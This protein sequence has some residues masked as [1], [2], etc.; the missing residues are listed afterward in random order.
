[1]GSYVPSSQAERE[2]MLK[3]IGVKSVEDL[4]AN[5]PADMLLKGELDLPSGLSELEVEQAMSETA[6][7]NKT[8]KT[9]LRGCGAY[10]HHIPS[11]VKSV[12]NKEQFVTAYTPYQ[13]EI[14]Q[15]ILQ[16]IFEY[17]TMICSLTGM[18]V[19]NA[20]VYDGASATAEAAAMCR[21]RKRNTVYISQAVNPEYIKVLKTYAFGSDTTVVTVPCVNGKTDKEALKNLLNEEAACFILQTP[22]YYGLFEDASEIG[23]IV[24]S[25]GAKFVMNCNPIALAIMKTPAEC[26]ADVAIGDGQPLGM[27]VA[28]GGPYLGFMASK[29]AMARKLPGRI[30]GQTV[31][32]E[33]KRGFV[34]TLQAREQHIRREK[35]SSNICSNQA[36][37]ALTAGVYMSAMG[38]Y[39][40]KRAATL[41]M[42]K[43]H[44]L[45]SELTKIEGVSLTFDGEFF[46][47]FTAV[48]PKAD[49]I[50]AKLDENGILGGYP[51]D[52]GI[53]WCAT[54][55]ATKAEL[56]RT[57]EIVKEVL[58]K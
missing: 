41:S 48:M 15:G 57:V 49:E 33:G 16:S 56:D 42:S 50:L 3:V 36:L 45:A 25:F 35:A 43:A 7:K 18:D 30:V 8:Y 39:G 12:V 6:G 14:S 5:V 32:K 19:S 54:E 17:Q 31:D 1:M 11:I 22:N 4:Y 47:E 9:I 21:E 10:N 52:C 13:A 29:N 20:S 55:L 28:F 46:H 34:L 23:E 58:S 40:M 53:I 26:G 44:Y 24:H 38:E 2:E 51:S 37:C 27:S